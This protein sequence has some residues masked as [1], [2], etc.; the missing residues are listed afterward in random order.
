METELVVGHPSWKLVGRAQYD[1]EGKLRKPTVYRTARRL[2]EGRVFLEEQSWHDKNLFMRSVLEEDL[3]Y[4]HAHGGIQSDKH[5]T[6]SHDVVL[7][8]P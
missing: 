1:G 8:F 2:M 4:I 3:C 6:G 7:T 5:L